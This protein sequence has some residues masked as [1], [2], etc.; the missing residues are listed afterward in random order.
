MSR[1]DFEKLFKNLGYSFKDRDLLKA[2]LTHRSVKAANNERLEFLGDSIVNFI[3]AEVLYSH[4]AH[5]KE[6]ELT[7][8]RSLLVKGETLAALA[9]ELEIGQYLLLGTGELKTGGRNRESILAD[10]LEAVIAGIYHDGGMDIC[11]QC[12]LSWYGSRIEQLSEIRNSQDPKTQL[13]EFLQ[14][15]GQGLPI[16]TVVVVR[17]KA[18][19][20][21][22]V[23]SCKIKTL[24]KLIQAEGSSRRRA[25]QQAAAMMLRELEQR[26]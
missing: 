9:K 22:F 16:Y 4:Y 25:E 10:S 1:Q 18:H 14:S 2:A 19:E 12:V 23:V 7:R 11:R 13:Q 17:G 15:R 8:Y 20:Q 21:I 5:S 3:I 24:D 6:G 26:V